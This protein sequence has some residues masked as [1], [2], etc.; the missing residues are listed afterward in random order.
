MKRGYPKDCLYGSHRGVLA[1]TEQVHGFVHVLF[2]FSHP[3]RVSCGARIEP[4]AWSFEVLLKMLTYPSSRQRISRAR[5]LLSRVGSKRDSGYSA[6]E[7]V[8]A[9]QACAL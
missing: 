4:R 7:V 5:G 9:D 8:H 2:W 3:V 1:R 6:V